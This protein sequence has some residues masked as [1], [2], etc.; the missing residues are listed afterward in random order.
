MNL[1]DEKKRDSTI[2]SNIM[3]S[4]SKMYVGLSSRV[5]FDGNKSAKMSYDFTSTQPHTHTHKHI[6]KPSCPAFA[7]DVGCTICGTGV[8]NAHTTATRITQNVYMF[9]QAM[10]I[11]GKH[12]TV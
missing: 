10:F 6:L 12:T 7:Y 3:R 2:W 8:S 4:T 11:K 9:G 5:S 1:V